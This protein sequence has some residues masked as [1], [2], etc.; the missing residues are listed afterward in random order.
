[1]AQIQIKWHNIPQNVTKLPIAA[2]FRI[3]CHKRLFCGTFGNPV[4]SDSFLWH[5]IVIYVTE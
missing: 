3:L 5:R 1:M 4:P 2:Y